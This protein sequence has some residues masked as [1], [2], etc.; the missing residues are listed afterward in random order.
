MSQMDGV[1]D[2][3]D[4]IKQAMKFGMSAV[5]ITDHNGALLILNRK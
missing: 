1:A 4:I 2:E 3:C 5:A